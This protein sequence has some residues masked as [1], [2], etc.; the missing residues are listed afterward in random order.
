EKR[1]SRVAPHDYTWRVEPAPPPAAV[2]DHDASRQ[3]G[4][5]TVTILASPTVQEIRT[6]SKSD[7]VVHSKGTAGGRRQGGGSRNLE[8]RWRRGNRPGSRGGPHDVSAA[9]ATQSPMFASMRRYEGVT[10][11][12]AAGQIV[13]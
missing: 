5:R 10:D 9:I 6:G 1:Y 4:A 3:V 2:A 12:V 13:Q 7:E 11:P 8:G